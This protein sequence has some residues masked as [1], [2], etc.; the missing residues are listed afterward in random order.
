M[1]RLFDPIFGNKVKKFILHLY[2]KINSLDN[3]STEIQCQN[4]RNVGTLFKASASGWFIGR[5][6]ADALKS[7]PTR[8]YPPDR[9]DITKRCPCIN[10]NSAFGQAFQEVGDYEVAA[11]YED[12]VGGAGGGTGGLPACGD[13]GEG[14]AVEAVLGG[15]SG[16]GGGVGGA[17]GVGLDEVVAGAAGEVAGDG[18]D[19]FVGGEAEDD[20]EGSGAGIALR[21]NSGEA[22][23]GI[24]P[25]TGV[26]AG[27]AD[28][29]WS[30]RD[31]LPASHQPG[32]RSYMGKALAD[33]LGGDGV[34]LLFEFLQCRHHGVG[35]VPLALAD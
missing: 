19:V 5:P 2:R 23:A 16:E 17:G 30:L 18:G 13:G 27:V 34:A 1:S 11:A 12:G 9:P 4:C 32:H 31:L 25:G 28:D 33:S 29:A 24:L 8:I 15:K 10:E 20:V 26:V 6:L 14:W 3:F 21:R 35:V 22:R 7:V